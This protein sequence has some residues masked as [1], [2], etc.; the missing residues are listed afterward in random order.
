M[1]KQQNPK[2]VGATWRTAIRALQHCAMV[3]RTQEVQGSPYSKP[4]RK[5]GHGPKAGSGS[6]LHMEQRCRDATAGKL[7]CALAWGPRA[8]GHGDRLQS[9]REQLAA[10]EAQPRPSSGEQA[11]G[12]PTVSS[13]SKSLR[14]V[15]LQNL[16]K[17]QG[18]R[19]EAQ[20]LPSPPQS[21]PRNPK[22]TAAG[23]R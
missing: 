8:G 21:Q 14:A 5:M 3:P 12:S 20:G 19:V 6:L 15:T 17:A 10:L 13:S 9:V 7:G 1:F 4:H 23:G 2:G 18:W 16:L 22:P 11:E